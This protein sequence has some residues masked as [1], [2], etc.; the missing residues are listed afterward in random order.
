MRC[1]SV[2]DAADEHAEY[3]N[4]RGSLAG[5]VN[6]AQNIKC[7]TDQA[8]RVKLVDELVEDLLAYGRMHSWIAVK[9]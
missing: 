2:T 5:F 7:T 3:T 1:S 6:D 4:M 8:G 9:G